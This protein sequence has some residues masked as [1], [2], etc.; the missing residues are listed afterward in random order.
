MSN[1]EEIDPV[2][3][4]REAKDAG[5]LDSNVTIN[6]VHCHALFPKEYH[7]CPQCKTN[8]I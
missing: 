2:E 4:V 8:G 3:L 1:K 7:N 6:C 5:L